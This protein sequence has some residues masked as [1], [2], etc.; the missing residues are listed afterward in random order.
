MSA[1]RRLQV[2]RQ[3]TGSS[4]ALCS[5]RCRGSF[6][7]PLSTGANRSPWRATASEDHVHG[8][9]LGLMPRSISSQVTGVETLAAAVGRR[10]H[11]RER[12][13][14]CV[15]V[16]VDQHAPARPLRDPV[17]GRQ[18]SGYCSASVIAS[19]FVNV[20]TSFCVGPRLIGTYTWM[21]LEPLVFAYEG[22]SAC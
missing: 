4:L 6:T 19:A 8:E 3:P 20:H 16:V 11:A 18:I 5:V 10:I 7:F 9:L 1:S 2:R 22:I 12:A 17:L 21:P 13:A 14:P 15:L